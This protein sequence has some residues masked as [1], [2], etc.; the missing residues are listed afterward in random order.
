MQIWRQAMVKQQRLILLVLALV[1]GCAFHPKAHNAIAD[2]N[3]A[4]CPLDQAQSES[5]AEP[6]ASDTAPSFSEPVVTLNV[7]VEGPHG[8][9][10]PGTYYTHPLLGDDG[11]TE[12]TLSKDD[13]VVTRF[14]LHPALAEP[15]PITKE[16]GFPRV[17]TEAVLSTNQKSVIFTVFEG[18]DRYE[19]APFPII[20]E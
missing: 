9:L 5:G 8:I 16:T 1:L 4:A 7:A 18:P 15:T 6:Q 13:K 14:P 17:H 19:S 20:R 11:Y 10:Q 12:L 2:D 3:T